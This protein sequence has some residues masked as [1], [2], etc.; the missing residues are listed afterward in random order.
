MEE[1][2]SARSD[3]QINRIQAGAGELNPVPERP[4]I[5]ELVRFRTP[6]AA[7]TIRTDLARPTLL[8]GSFHRSVSPSRKN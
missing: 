4:D 1:R 2:R 6:A 3:R 5:G 8:I 7:T